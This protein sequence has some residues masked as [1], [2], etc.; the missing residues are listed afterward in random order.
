MQY[1]HPKQRLKGKNKGLWFFG[2]SKTTISPIKEYGPFKTEAEAQ[3]H[4]DFLR[5]ENR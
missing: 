1:Y 4:Q 3:K 5:K 2:I